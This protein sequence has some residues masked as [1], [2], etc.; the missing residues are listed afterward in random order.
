[1]ASVLFLIWKSFGNEF[2]E[3]CLQDEGYEVVSFDF[4]R[5]SE[6]VRGSAALTEEIARKIF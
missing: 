3:K 1:M 2:M 4:P 6:D 5:E